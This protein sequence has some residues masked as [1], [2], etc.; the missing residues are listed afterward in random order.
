MQKNWKN[1]IPSLIALEMKKLSE[2]VYIWSTW[3][4]W[5]RIFIEQGIDH[6]IDIAFTKHDMPQLTQ[7]F[8]Q[9]NI[10]FFC[11]I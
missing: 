11:S 5:I 9:I 4:S 7:H 6:W 8:C 3:W 2:N 10:K 1:K